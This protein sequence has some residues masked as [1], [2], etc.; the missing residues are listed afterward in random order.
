[1]TPH[2][3]KLVA[4]MKG[5]PFVFVGV[6]AD[7]KKETVRAFLKKHEMPWTHWWVGSSEG[8]MEDWQIG[9]LPTIYLID[10]RGVLREVLV[11]ADHEK[12]AAVAERLVQEAE[13][14]K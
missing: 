6:S 10:A 2:S 9:A 3:K 4:A 1:M 5:R 7:E 13:R 11:G 14:K 12:L 8:L